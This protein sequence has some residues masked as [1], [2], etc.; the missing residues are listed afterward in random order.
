MQKNLYST[1]KCDLSNNNNNL[2]YRTKTKQ[3][4]DMSY[5]EKKKKKKNLS[6]LPCLEKNKLSPIRSI[7]RHLVLS[8][9]IKVQHAPVIT[10]LV[11]CSTW[12]QLSRW[13]I[14]GQFVFS[15]HLCAILAFEHQ[16]QVWKLMV[17]PPVECCIFKNIS[18]SGQYDVQICDL[19]TGD[20][21]R[22]DL[23]SF[24][25]GIKHLWGRHDRHTVNMSP[26]CHGHIGSSSLS[27]M[28]TLGL[29][30][31]KQKLI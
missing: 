7:I 6:F 18:L 28:E 30:S 8:Q 22:H 13:G 27:G 20:R 2:S 4:R 25:I 26:L 24:F 12:E 15:M 11:S 9:K 14:S 31:Q 29:T 21:H 16:K 10:Y 1:R 5:S 23:G 19:A 17:S 3:L